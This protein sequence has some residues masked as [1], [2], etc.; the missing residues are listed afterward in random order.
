M[1]R[2]KK[3]VGVEKA[4]GK[5]HSLSGVRVHGIKVYGARSRRIDR[6][7]GKVYT[8]YGNVLHQEGFTDLSQ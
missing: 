3:C 6:V 2:Q 8:V 7:R 5:Q 1:E 4:N